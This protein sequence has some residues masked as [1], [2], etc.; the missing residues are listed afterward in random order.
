MLNI[1]CDICHDKEKGYYRSVVRNGKVITH[2]NDCTPQE[3]QETSRRP[4]T[5][6]EKL[7]L[8]W[9]RDEKKWIE[10]IQSRKTV[11]INGKPTVVSNVG[12]MPRQPEQYYRNGG[13]TK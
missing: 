3:T 4:L 8:S 9:Y 2:C 6:H 10:N 13:R 5:E 12:I 11:N 7:K 1:A